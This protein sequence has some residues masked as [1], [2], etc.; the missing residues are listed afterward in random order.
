MKKE[1]DRE[2]EEKKE[3]NREKGTKKGVISR[4]DDGIDRERTTKN[5]S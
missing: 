2:G 3:K 1:E 4:S 5:R